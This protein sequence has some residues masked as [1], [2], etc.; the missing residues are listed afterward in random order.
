MYRTRLM[1]SFVTTSL[2]W[3]SMFVT[4]KWPLRS[5]SVAALPPIV[6][7]TLVTYLTRTAG[8]SPR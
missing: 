7:T 6:Q 8:G 2:P 5:G 3:A 1:S 4:W